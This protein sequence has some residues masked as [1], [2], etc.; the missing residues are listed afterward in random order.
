MIR[1]I[2]EGSEARTQLEFS[3][4]VAFVDFPEGTNEC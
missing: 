3:L 2:K 1:K 4:F